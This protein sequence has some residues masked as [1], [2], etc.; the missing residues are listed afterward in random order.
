MAISQ[1]FV[2]PLAGVDAPGGGA[3]GA[4][5]KTVQYALNT[6]V[7]NA[8]DGDQINIKA[9][10]ADVLGASLSLVA[11]G[12]PS[13]A[14]P[15]IFRGYTAAA[16]DGGIGEING[17][18]NIIINYLGSNYGRWMYLIDL[19]LTSNVADYVLRLQL[20]NIIENCYIAN[21]LGGTI[22][23]GTTLTVRQCYLN[24]TGAFSLRTN[25]SQLYLTESV[26]MCNGTSTVYTAAEAYITECVFIAGVINA[27][28]IYSNAS[29]DISVRNCSFYSSLANT[30]RAIDASGPYSISISNCIFEGWSGVGGA[31]IDLDNVNAFVDQCAFYN[32]TA[33]IVNT[34]RL[35]G[36]TTPIILAASP[37]VNAAAGNFAI[38]DVA[39][40][41]GVGARPTFNAIAT[42]T[43]IDIGAAQRQE[44]A[45]V[46]GSV[47]ISPYRGN[48]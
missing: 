6:I 15:I 22:H 12:T 10:A 44:V 30:G 3:I 9:G 33:N 43:Y 28:G 36:T 35:Y 46:G 42:N 16:N 26:I 39:T 23:G 24:G 21:T 47:S 5:W 29:G 20:A 32:N 4:P 45:A 31:A 40:L 41:K 1:Y 18:G 17:N 8:V 37:F 2:D 7:R 27:V 13:P 25:N 19:K 34:G 48:L 14:A 11:Y 38:N